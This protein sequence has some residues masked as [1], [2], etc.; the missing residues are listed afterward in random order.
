MCC[1]VAAQL[2]AHPWLGPVVGKGEVELKVFGR[3]GLDRRRLA[4]VDA[5]GGPDE[6]TKD[7]RHKQGKKPNHRADMS[8]D[9][10]S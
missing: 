6:E 1:G 10:P 4:R 5:V 8:R 3:E 7:Q 2:E 9:P